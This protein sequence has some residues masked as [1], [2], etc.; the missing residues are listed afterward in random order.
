MNDKSQSAENFLRRL[1]TR[2]FKTMGMNQMAYIREVKVDGQ[3]SFA[4][5]AA[6]GTQLA[7][8]DSAELAM[9]SVLN[10]DMYPV[11]VH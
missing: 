9:A 1:S 8:N 11:T 10:N 6:D 4:V 2:D 7:V 3:L 5:H